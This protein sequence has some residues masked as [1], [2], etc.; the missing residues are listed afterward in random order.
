MDVQRLEQSPLLRESVDLEELGLQGSFLF[1][2]IGVFDG[3]AVAA[4]EGVQGPISVLEGDIDVAELLELAVGFGLSIGGLEPELYRD[5]RLWNVDVLGLTLAIGEADATTVVLS[6]GSLSG[7]APAPD[8]VK[9]SLDGFDGLGPNFLENP[10][11]QRLL[12]RLPSGFITTLLARCGALGELSAIIELP[13]CAAA[14]VSADVVG[15]DAVVFY[16]LAG[17]EDE[18]AAAAVVQ[19][20]LERIEAEARLPFGNVAVGQE[21]ELVWTRVIVEPEQI[22][23]ALDSLS[24]PKP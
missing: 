7:G 18:T 10:V 16:G 2:A 23:Q 24:L 11:F 8:L 17:F 9:A 19:V 21:K 3:L 22:T 15:E 12:G 5:H 4:G 13:G 6:S 14:A 1:D 20:A